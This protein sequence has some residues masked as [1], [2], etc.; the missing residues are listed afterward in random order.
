M[1]STELRSMKVVGVHC[2]GVRSVECSEVES[3]V[4]SMVER[5]EGAV[6]KHVSRKQLVCIVGVLACCKVSRLTVACSV[7]VVCMCTHGPHGD[8]GPYRG[9]KY[10]PPHESAT[11]RYAIGDM[12]PWLSERFLLAWRWSARVSL[13]TGLAR[14][15]STVVPSISIPEGRRRY[16]NRRGPC[17]HAVTHTER[18][19]E[20]NIQVGHCRFVSVM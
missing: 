3:S 12:P 16:R 9:A 10:D 6:R 18:D 20:V 15:T 4:E 1:H 5:S 14:V 13:S 17:P 7:G 2:D 11:G 8:G 19:V